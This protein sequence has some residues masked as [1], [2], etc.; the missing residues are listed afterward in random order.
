MSG[1]PKGLVLGPIVFNDFIDDLDDGI[2]CILSK[3]AE[4]PV[5]GK[6]LICLSLGRPY[7]GT[8]A[9]WIDGLTP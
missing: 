5:W 3:F 2:E 4:T 8:W 9:G 6:V 7:R 1:L